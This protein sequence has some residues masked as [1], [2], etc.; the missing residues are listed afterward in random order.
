MDVLHMLQGVKALTFG[1]VAVCMARLTLTSLASKI[2]L[3]GATC[4]R[5]ASSIL[6]QDIAENIHAVRKRFRFRTKCPSVVQYID[7]YPNMFTP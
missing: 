7:R 1:T 2:A 5:L 6:C 4:M 3:H